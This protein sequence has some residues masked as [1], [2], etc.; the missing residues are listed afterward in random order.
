VAVDPGEDVVGISRHSVEF[1]LS[2]GWM[3]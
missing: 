2:K 1:L 3:S